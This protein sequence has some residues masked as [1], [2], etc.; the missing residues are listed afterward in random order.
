VRKNL[1]RAACYAGDVS[2]GTFVSISDPVS[3]QI[4][5]HSNYAW[6][7]IDMEHGPVPMAALGGIINAIRATAT[8]PFVR[9]Q[10]NTSAAIQVA[11]DHGA[12]GV[13]VPMVNTADDARSAVGDVRF[14]PLGARSRGG[15]RVG[16]SFD[17]D[18]PTYFRE[19]NDE[20]LLMA[21]IETAEAIEN[22]DEIAALAGIDCLFVGPND[23]A[24]SYGLEYPAAW[25]GKSGGYAAAIDAVPAA[26]KRHGKI[27]G[28]LAG[29]PAMA[30]ECIERGYT[31]V[32]SGT[33]ATMLWEAARR[34][35]AEIKA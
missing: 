35:R 34:V 10:W 26:A 30:N 31:L 32:G 20:V 19:A 9:A 17:T 16:L 27:A 6:L 3:A 5:A 14:S 4:F 24:A 12:S 11:L 28:I 2:I 13:M 23:L 7:V 29:S 33:D 18:S 1:V 25:Q 8:E 21:Q 22:L 15:V